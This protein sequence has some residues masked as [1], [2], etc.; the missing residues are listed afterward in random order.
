M[1]YQ[2]NDEDTSLRFI[3]ASAEAAGGIEEHLRSVATAHGRGATALAASALATQA[4]MLRQA[5]TA[6]AAGETAIGV[7]GGPET[8]PSWYVRDE[9]GMPIVED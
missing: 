1:G 7:P 9:N 4:M 6:F 8:M 3:R 2:I 5:L